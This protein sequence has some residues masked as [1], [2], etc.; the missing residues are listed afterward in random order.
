M[1]ESSEILKHLFIDQDSS[2][3]KNFKDNIRA[4]KTMFSFT[5][6]GGKIDKSF[7]NGS[8][9]YIFRMYSENYHRI[10]SLLPNENDPPRFT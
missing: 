2:S 4:Y 7:N 3:S 8:A 10:G 5:S 9:P 1:K 6:M